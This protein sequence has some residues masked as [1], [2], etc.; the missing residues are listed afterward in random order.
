MEMNHGNRVWLHSV[1]S[2]SASKLTTPALLSALID[3]YVSPPQDAF[4][5]CSLHLENKEFFFLIEL[6]DVS[7]HLHAWNG[8]SRITGRSFHLVSGCFGIKQ[9]PYFSRSCTILNS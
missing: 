7:K 6:S 2:A 8:K 1:T 9:C 3:I 4:L 5:R